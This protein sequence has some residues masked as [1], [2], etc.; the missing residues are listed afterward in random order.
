LGEIKLV[1]TQSVADWRPQLDDLIVYAKKRNWEAVKPTMHR[2]KGQLGAIGLGRLADTCH[3][4]TMAIK[5]GSTEHLLD[6]LTEF[7]AELRK[8][9]KATE[10]DITLQL[11]TLDDES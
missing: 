10:Q 5:D 7:V 3:D 2:L 6:V 8:I 9:L 11:P 4:V 1:L